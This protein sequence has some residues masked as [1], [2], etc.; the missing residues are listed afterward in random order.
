M[1]IQKISKSVFVFSFPLVMP[2]YEGNVN[3]GLFLGKEKNYIFDTSWKKEHMEEIIHFLFTISPDKEV[4]IFNSHADF[5]HFMGNCAFPN[6]EIIATEL[7]YRFMKKQSR[8]KIQKEYGIKLAKEDKILLPNHFA[9]LGYYN[10]VERF[11][12]F[13][14]PIHSMD[15]ACLYV[16][17]KQ[18]L[19]AGDNIEAPI[20]YLNHDNFELIRYHYEILKQIF[21]KFI[22]PGHGEVCEGYQLLNENIAYLDAL[23]KKDT[24]KYE[25]PPYAEI[26]RTNMEVLKWK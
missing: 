10:H 9:S 23:I 5:D 7:C 21:P 20:P 3:V 22:V 25:K 6:S 15:S 19:F 4:A 8:R 17:Q 24:A 13:P 18:I 1:K 26:H 2:D 12:F 14:S 16:K 11:D